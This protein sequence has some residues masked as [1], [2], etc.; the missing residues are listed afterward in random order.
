MLTNR[1]PPAPGHR[2]TKQSPLAE[3]DRS[4]LDLAYYSVLK[5]VRDDQYPK[6]MEYVLVQRRLRFSRM[7]AQ[8]W[9]DVRR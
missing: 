6:Y 1:G 5:L 2:T 3:P 7:E 4:S 8:W 9:K